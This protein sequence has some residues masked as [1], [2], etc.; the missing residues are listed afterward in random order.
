MIEVPIKKCVLATIESDFQGHLIVYSGDSCEDMRC[1]SNPYVFYG[2]ETFPLSFAGNSTYFLAVVKESHEFGGRFNMTFE[3]TECPGLDS[4]EEAGLVG[5]IPFVTSAS[6]VFATAELPIYDSPAYRCEQL[7]SEGRTHWYVIPEGVAQDRCFTA[8]LYA[9]FS[10]F[11]GV[12]SSGPDDNCADL[13]CLYSENYVNGFAR[14]RGDNSTLY[15]VVA[16]AYG[17]ASGDYILT[18]AVSASE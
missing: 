4:C 2:E 18:I 7:S 3:E 15:V 8:F 11:I 1:A 12:Y 13:N 9:D 10:S 6:N 14:F 16:G 17:Y 5:E